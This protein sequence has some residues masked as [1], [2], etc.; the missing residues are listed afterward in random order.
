MKFFLAVLALLTAIS[1]GQMPVQTRAVGNCPRVT[2]ADLGRT[3]VLNNTGLVSLAT[4]T[5][6]G[7]ERPLVRILEYQVVCEAAGLTRDTVSATSVVVRYECQ[8]VMQVCPMFVL[9]QY[10]NL[11]CRTSD[12]FLVP[13]PDVQFGSEINPA[14]NSGLSVPLNTQCGVCTERNSGTDHCIRKYT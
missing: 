11:D 8:G 10:L 5:P 3:D 2:E 9:V 4:L 12:S 7:I 6:N 14:N 13:E 1:D